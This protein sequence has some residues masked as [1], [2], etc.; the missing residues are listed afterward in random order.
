MVVAQKKRAKK[1]RSAKKT[2]RREKL[3]RLEFLRLEIIKSKG[4]KLS[5]DKKKGWDMYFALEIEH[6]TDP[7]KMVGMSFPSSP[8]SFTNKDNNVYIFGHNGNKDREGTEVYLGPI[9]SDRR[10]NVG[11][12]AI[13]SK[14]K[15]RST[16]NIMQTI[17]GFADSEVGTKL[18]PAAAEN[19]YVAA[20]IVANK[21]VNVIGKLLEQ[22]KDK[23]RGRADLDEDFSD[24][25]FQRK[26][27]KGFRIE[28]SGHQIALLYRWS[29]VSS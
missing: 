28:F 10:I 3:V 20:A 6:P 18:G 23:D 1:N 2:G 14:Q 12:Q 29:I 11:V 27:K 17:T 15:T 13:Q 22:T 26:G 19:P 5:L 21:G 7:S 16:G 24:A 8:I 25:A 4:N 9:P